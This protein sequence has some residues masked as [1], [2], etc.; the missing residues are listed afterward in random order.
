MKS[1]FMLMMREIFLYI[2]FK[3]LRILTKRLIF[4]KNT[5]VYIEFFISMH[6][7]T[8]LNHSSGASMKGT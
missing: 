7:H 3:K 6:S 2:D 1:R 4:L 8:L 5:A